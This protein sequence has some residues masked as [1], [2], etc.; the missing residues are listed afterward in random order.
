MAKVIVFGSV[1][2]DL[3]VECKRMPRPGETLTG[4]GF[5][6]N[7]GGKGANQAVAAARMG[8]DVRMIGC[9]GDDVF[10]HELVEGLSSAD[11]DVSDVVVSPESPTGT[12]TILRVEG[13]NRIVVCPGANV[14]RKADDVCA[15]LDRLSEPGDVLLCQLEC[16]LVTTGEII[17]HA[18]DRGLLTVLNAAPAHRLDS[19]VYP[20]VDVLCV[21]ETE[22]EALSGVLPTDRWRQRDAL[23]ALRR[24]GVRNAIITLGKQG[25]ITMVGDRMVRT[26]AF[27]AK[28]VDTTGA[29][30]AFLGALAQQ[31]AD[32]IPI[33]RSLERASVAGTLAI[34]KVGAQQAMP[35]LRE[36][37]SFLGEDDGREG[38]DVR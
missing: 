25:S 16:D 28:A 5:I 4:W 34:T 38:V 1:N 7:P 23:L 37:R 19:S 24:L 12:A 31:V 32:G 8:A 18:H 2:M 36:V 27:P 30:D 21:N 35:T 3:S 20:N 22:C 17:G 9:V 15:V 29:G 10:G 11:V 6:T 33:E 14:E 13:E 26:Q